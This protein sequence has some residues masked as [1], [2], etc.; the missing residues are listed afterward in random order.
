MRRKRSRSQMAAIDQINVTPLLD[1]T[2]LLLIVFMI[3]MPLMEYG[4]S[5]NPPEMNADKLPETDFKKRHIDQTGHD[6]FRSGD[7]YER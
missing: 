1:L 7:G 2:F 6:R 3:T 4:T 5:V